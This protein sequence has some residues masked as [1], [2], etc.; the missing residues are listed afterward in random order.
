MLN[1]HVKALLNLMEQRAIPPLHTLPPAQARILYRERKNLTQPAPPGVAEV[2]EL[3]SFGPHGPIPLR[4][5]RPAGAKVDTVLPVLVYYHG[6]GFV[7]GDLETHDTLCRELCNG[8]GCAVVA[9]DYRL[10]P[11]FRFPCAVDDCLAATYWVA[12][13]AQPLKI[14]PTR[15]AVGGDS[16]GGNLA[17]VIAILA[18][19]AGDLAIAFQLLIYPITDARCVAQS[20]T[21]NGQGYML[22]NDTMDYFLRHYLTDESEKLNLKASPLLSADL[23]KLP[24][25]FVLTAGYDPL[26]DEGLQYAQRLNESGNVASYNCFSRQIHGYIPMCR[27]LEEANAAVSMCA[28]ELRRQLLVGSP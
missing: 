2:R 18:R 1:P 28:G 15:V 7:I 13:N 25:A 5:Y 14:D 19:D 22:T 20:H 10:A 8:S 9:V 6:G 27:A 21:T 16:A 11:E 12:N 26:H 4:M 17:A 3:Q 23:S 24:P